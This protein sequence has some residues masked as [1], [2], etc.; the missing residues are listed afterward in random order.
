LTVLSSLGTAAELAGDGPGVSD[1]LGGGVPLSGT[2]CA[3]G[4]G[5]AAAAAGV[6]DWH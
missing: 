6:V 3:V 2:V 4:I 1:E 5:A